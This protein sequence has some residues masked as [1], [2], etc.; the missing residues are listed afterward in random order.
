MVK[1]YIPGVC[2]PDNYNIYGRMRDPE[3]MEFA[4]LDIGG[5]WVRE[6]DYDAV[7]ALVREML[8]FVGMCRTAYRAGPVSDID[9]M[10]DLM[11]RAGGVL[12]AD[13]APACSTCGGRG[14]YTVIRIGNEVSVPCEDCATD[15]ASPPPHNYRCEHDLQV[16][17]NTVV[18]TDEGTRAV[19]V[20]CAQEWRTGA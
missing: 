9:A 7:V 16:K 8:P 18:V 2:Q 19:C 20:Y 6:E 15:S 1:R 13:S 12:A 5:K 17:G 11:S 14:R 10:N 3:T 4:P